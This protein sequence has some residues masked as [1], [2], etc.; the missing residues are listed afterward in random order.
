M[1]LFSVAVV[2][3][4][5]QPTR[6]AADT[7]EVPSEFFFSVVSYTVSF[8]LLFFRPLKVLAGELIFMRSVVKVCEPLSEKPPGELFPIEGKQRRKV[9]PAGNRP[10]CR[11]ENADQNEA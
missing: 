9:A 5:P 1:V 2:L 7:T 8:F 10:V 11:K 3:L 4:L 6:A